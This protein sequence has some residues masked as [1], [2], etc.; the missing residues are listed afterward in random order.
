MT[1]HEVINKNTKKGKATLVIQGKRQY[2]G[3]KTVTFN[4]QAKKLHQS[5]ARA[6]LKIAE[7]VQ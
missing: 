5:V 1:A 4:I 2:G 6:L 3:T 7:A